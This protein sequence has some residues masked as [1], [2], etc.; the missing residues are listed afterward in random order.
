M[1]MKS[2]NDEYCGLYCSCGCIEGVVLK[3]EAD[4]DFGY[5]LSLVSDIY[6]IPQETG[7]VR[8]KEKCKRIWK[9]LRNKEHCYFS[10]YISPEDMKEFKEFVSKI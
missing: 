5:E 2:G 1:I 3:S 6:Y 4:E 8:F 7:W 10:I 9:I